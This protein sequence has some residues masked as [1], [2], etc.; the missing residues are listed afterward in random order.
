MVCIFNGILLSYKK[1]ILPFMT[2]W[3]KF[4][5]IM[6]NEVSQ[7]SHLHLESKNIKL[8]ETEGRLIV[9]RGKME[10]IVEGGQRIQTSRYKRTKFWGSHVHHDDYS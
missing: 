8:T 3:M 6:L 4:Q 7:I 9:A 10:V 5:G 1:A 2:T